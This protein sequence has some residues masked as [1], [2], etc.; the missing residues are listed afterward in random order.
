MQDTI[1]R[2]NAD[3][4]IKIYEPEKA[5]YEAVIS[6]ADKG[7]RKTEW[8]PVSV[9]TVWITEGPKE[10]QIHI[11]VTEEGMREYT[12]N[13]PIT[14]EEYRKFQ[15]YKGDKRRLNL[16]AKVAKGKLKY[17][18]LKK[19]EKVEVRLN[20]RQMQLLNRNAELCGLTTSA[21]ARQLLEGKHPRAA[22]TDAEAR[23]IEELIK[24]RS[25]MLNFYNA[26]KAELAKI[27]REQRTAFIV[28][29]LS[30]KSFRDYIRASLIMLD[31]MIGDEYNEKK[32]LEYYEANHK[33]G[34]RE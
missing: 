14:K 15:E 24:L 18:N 5:F 12:L 30:Y 31:K 27:P 3:S 16:V 33:G 10:H 9:G 29:G 32:M 20:A 28:L 2:F 17:K 21:Y 13:F 4:Y 25:D 6:V 34:N 26:S 23:K 8:H 22:F 1:Y 19:T 7:S 11:P